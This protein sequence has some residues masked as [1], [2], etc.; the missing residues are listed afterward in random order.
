M[1]SI[2]ETAPGTSAIP[3]TFATK[4]TWDAIAAALPHHARQFALGNGFAAKPGA[5]LTLPAADGS[6]AQVL[7]GLENADKQIPRS[8][9]ARRL[10]GPAASGGLSLRQRAA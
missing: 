3:I 2:F 10:A 4:A 1:N 6:I 7:F 5:C 9:P 8:V